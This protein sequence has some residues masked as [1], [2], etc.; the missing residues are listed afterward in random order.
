MF[1]AKTNG[2][3]SERQSCPWGLTEREEK[4][5]RSSPDVC[6]SRSSSKHSPCI[7]K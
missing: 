2:R 3:F 1:V 4:Y 6:D 7:G 5:D